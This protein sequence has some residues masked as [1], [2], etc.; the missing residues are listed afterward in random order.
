M[1]HAGTFNPN[2]R[3][4]RLIVLLSG[5]LAIFM[6]FA[7]NWNQAGLQ[8]P[9][10]VLLIV[11]SI[12][13]ITHVSR[14]PMSQFQ[15]GLLIAAV[16][17][18][19]FVAVRASAFLIFLDIIS[20]LMLLSIYALDF[21][22]QR[23]LKL[24]EYVVHT[25][26]LPFIAFPSQTKLARSLELKSIQQLSHTQKSIIR[27]VLLAL[28]LLIV[29][30]LLFSAADAV[31]ADAAKRLFSPNISISPELVGRTVVALIIIC[32]VA[33]VLAYMFLIDH[34]DKDSS[35]KTDEV[36]KGYDLEMRIVLGLVN[37]LFFVF[38]LIQA[39]YLFGSRDFVLNGSLTYAEYGRSGFFEL[40]FVSVLVFALAYGVKKFT[41]VG[42]NAISKYLLLALIGQVGVIMISALMR[43]G[44]YVD[45]YGLTELRFYSWSFI[46]FLIGAFALLV[47]WIVS[48]APESK[49]LRTLVVLSAGYIVMLNILNPDSMIATRNLQRFESTQNVD[50]LYMSTLSSDATTQK[51]DLFSNLNT[52]LLAD[53]KYYL[54]ASLCKTVRAQ[55]QSSW[56]TWN[57]SRSKGASDINQLAPSCIEVV[58]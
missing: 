52:K 3:I 56:S 13:Y 8:V 41:N 17:I 38:I 47:Y 2:V 31:F 32:A 5:L 18:S 33:P 40:L 19:A 12:V 36:L 28:P 44:L 27:G 50:V 43:L 37:S 30:G 9:F 48:H 42:A 4:A 55:E 58:D 1:K 10:S 23:P 57:L 11:A 7:S 6:S 20:V 54:D 45:V 16:V 26:L 21:A 22:W 46:F 35:D 53:E 39:V 51:L 29:F 34:K 15:A 14:R 49:L 24:I 25:W